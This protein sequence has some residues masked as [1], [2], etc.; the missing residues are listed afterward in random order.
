MND[1]QNALEIIRFGQPERILSGPPGHGLHYFGMNHESWDGQGGHHLP[2]GSTWTDIWG[3]VWSKEQDDVMG[4]PR[5]NPLADLAAL[6]TYRWP[7]PDDERLCGL[8]REKRQAGWDRE[9]QFLVGGHRDTLW[10]KAYML[11]GVENLMCL[12]H[13]DPEAVR[14][15]LH[16]IMDFQLG[17]ARHYLAA[18]VEMVNCGDDHGSQVGLLLSP[19]TFREFLVPEYRRLFEL[20]RKH[21]VIIS[22]HSC[23]HIQP[24]LETF[25]E[26]G[27][28]IL[29]PIQATA[30]NLREVRRITQGRLA[31]QGAVPTW[32]MMKGPPAAI[33]KIVAARVWDLGRA[34]GYFCAPDQGMPWPPEHYAAFT[35]ALAEFGRYPLREPEEI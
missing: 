16:R 17:M 28:S 27:I 10:E 6:K 19:E 32:L 30:N 31:L 8:I 3:T 13:T 5:G 29:N 12:F 23:G 2:T 20:Y 11:C 33:R 22:F 4:F 18:G 21:D 34:G 1:K 24:L 15:I 9:N 7:D 14:E 35:Q 25:I 26:L